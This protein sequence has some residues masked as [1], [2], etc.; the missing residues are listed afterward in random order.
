MKSVRTITT[1][2]GFTFTIDKEN[3][4]IKETLEKVINSEKFI[5]MASDIIGRYLDT[6]YKKN[7][8][9]LGFIAGKYLERFKNEYNL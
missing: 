5:L 2:E 9:A 1:K 4:V 3:E 7:I 6:T 8:F